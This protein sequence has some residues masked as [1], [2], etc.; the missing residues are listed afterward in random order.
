MET[1]V[2]GDDGDVGGGESGDSCKVGRAAAKVT[3]LMVVV[4]VVAKS[5]D[6]CYYRGVCNWSFWC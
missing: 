6:S 5:R 2:G 4:A 1:A 3:A